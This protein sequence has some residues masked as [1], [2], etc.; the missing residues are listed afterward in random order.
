[1][2][3]NSSGAKMWNNTFI[4]SLVAIGRTNRSAEADHFGWHPATGPKIPER[5]EHEFCNNLMTGDDAYDRPLLFVWQHPKLCGKQND[6]Q[7]KILNN[8]I[9]VHKQAEEDQDLILW[10]PSDN[11]AVCTK[12][13]HGPEMLNKQFQQFSGNSKVYQKG[14][15][16][17]FVGEHLKRFS[18]ASG[19][20]V[21]EDAA[22]IPMEIKKWLKTDAEQSYIGAYPPSR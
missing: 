11:H 7:L 19:L 8:N 22:E 16:Q 3:L 12:A 2:I 9:Y 5:K 6:S 14:K 10:G 13:Y 15:T 18:P 4:N 20:P 1:M 21:S 17:V